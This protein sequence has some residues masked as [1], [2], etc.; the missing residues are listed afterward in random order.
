MSVT[1]EAFEFPS[2]PRCFFSLP[3]KAANCHQLQPPRAAAS[4][5]SDTTQ[6]PVPLT[7]RPALPQRRSR[8][9]RADSAAAH[10]PVPPLRTAEPPPPLPVA[11]PGSARAAPRRLLLRRP[12]T[13]RRGRG[14][15]AVLG[16]GGRGLR[17]P[18]GARVGV[19]P[20]RE[21]WVPWPR[22]VKLTEERRSSEAPS[23]A[24]P[25]TLTSSRPLG[26]V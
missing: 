8:P 14:P 20:H 26:T 3:S 15:P 9:R 16:G 17:A 25:L 22:P 24:T 1:G 12:T 18:P 13:W 19:V 2:K 23:V 10:P 11:P 4:H 21:L 7:A 6:R 5:G